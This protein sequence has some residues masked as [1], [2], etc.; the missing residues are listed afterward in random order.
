MI[1]RYGLL[2][3]ILMPFAKFTDVTHYE[4]TKSLAPVVIAWGTT[5]LTAS[6]YG[7]KI[8]CTQI[9]MWDAPDF[10]IDETMLCTLNEAI[11][12]LDD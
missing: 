9:L 3:D 10:L 1:E 4:S 6:G 2:I 7:R 11:H 5:K 12:S 8:I